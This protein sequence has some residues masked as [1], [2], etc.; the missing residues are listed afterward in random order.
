[1]KLVLASRREDC[2]VV[3]A[4]AMR[5]PTHS[6]GCEA[7]KFSSWPHY[8]VLTEEKHYLVCDSFDC[9]F[10]AIRRERI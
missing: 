2:E 10:Q 9:V 5:L 1:M 8:H 7:Q 4:K 3:N 6:C